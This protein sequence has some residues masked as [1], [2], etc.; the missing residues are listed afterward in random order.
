MILSVPSSPAALAP[1]MKPRHQALVWRAYVPHRWVNNR[2]PHRTILLAA[3]LASRLDWAQNKPLKPWRLKLDDRFLFMFALG[4]FGNLF[5]GTLLANLFLGTLL[6]NLFLG[7]LLGKLFLGTLLGNPFL[8]TWE[9]CAVGFWLLRPASGK[10]TLLG[11][12]GKVKKTYGKAKK[13]NEQL[14]KN[15]ENDCKS[16]ENQ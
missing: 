12:S 15:K 7:T 9:P 4:C 8:G 2:R 14:K 16:K 1:R 11:K 6:G 5:L 10:L 13:T 3:S